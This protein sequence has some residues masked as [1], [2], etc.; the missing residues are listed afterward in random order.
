MAN[1]HAQVSK[2][3]RILL[4][5]FAPYIARELGNELGNN[6][7]DIAVINTLMGDQ[8]RNL[9]LSGD[10]A[11]LVDS[12][13]IA[14]CLTLFDIH[15]NK[16]F[17]KKLSIDHRTWAKELMGVR[18]KLAHIGGE[19]FTVDYTC[20]ALDTMSLLSE[21]IDPDGAEEIRDLLRITR[22]GSANGSTS[23]T[24]ASTTV[25]EKSKKGGILN[26]TP[27]NANQVLNSEIYVKLK[28]AQN[29]YGIE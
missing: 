8:K 25:A 14:R 9:P 13:D 1:N 23:V 18:N 3:F 29:P 21:Q 11:K 15:W 16:I 7:W 5:A 20:R 17:R 28:R 4:G 2:G 10:W 19:D 12:L 27:I 22:Y 24:E 26:T 6:W